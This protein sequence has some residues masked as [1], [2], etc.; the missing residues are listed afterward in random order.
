[1]STLHRKVLRRPADRWI[2][3][4]LAATLAV[5]LL[6]FGFLAEY[7]SKPGAMGT[8]PLHWP[9][10][11]T[12]PRADGTSTLI[13]FAHP[14]CGC[15]AA[16]LSELRGLVP[17]LGSATRVRVRFTVPAGMGADWL[18]TPNWR[19]ARAIAGV[20]VAADPDGIEARRFGALTSGVVVLYDG[21][22][23]LRF[24]GG[25]TPSRGHM[26]DSPGRTEILAAMNHRPAAHPKTPVFGCA[27]DDPNPVAAP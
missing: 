11:S 15:T 12:L 6:G 9:D 26:G 21:A 22:G 4:A 25:L 16:T 27:L 24:T 13:L 5:V 2:V 18:D 1:M 8:T 14:R 7:Q 3:G 17:Q 23:A 19:A 20:D 10:D